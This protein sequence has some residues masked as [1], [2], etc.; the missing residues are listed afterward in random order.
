MK[1]LIVA[2]LT[3]GLVAGAALVP[4][5]AAKKSKLKP[6]ET[7]FFLHWDDDG[8]GGCGPTS[9]STEDTEDAG[10]GCN[11]IFQPAQELLIASGQT[12]LTTLWP[13]ADGVPLRLDASR[14]VTGELTVARI[15]A[16]DSYVDIV[17]SGTAGGRSIEIGT[18]TSEKL[19]DGPGAETIEFDI[20]PKGA[21]D[22]KVFT[23]LELSTTIRGVTALTY[24]DLETSPSF[25]VVPGLR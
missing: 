9:M 1:K 10:N 12:M 22:K 14:K 5:A 3:L 23:A 19:N 15:A 6:T 2:A 16:L 20:A 24:V 11:F 7:T 4:A 18:F 8:S 21:L 13:A 25:V 17:L